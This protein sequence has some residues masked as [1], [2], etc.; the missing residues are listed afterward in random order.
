[1]HGARFKERDSY[2]YDFIVEVLC[3]ISI[4]HEKDELF[5]TFSVFVQLYNIVMIQL[6][7]YYTLLISKVHT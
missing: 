4:L 3:I 6:R 2:L 1:M 7:V 5:F